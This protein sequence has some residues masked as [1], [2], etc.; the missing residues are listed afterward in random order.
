MRTI[1]LL[2]HHE[3]VTESPGLLIWRV[4]FNTDDPHPYTVSEFIVWIEYDSLYHVA[5]F[6]RIWSVLQMINPTRME[7]KGTTVGINTRAGPEHLPH[8]VLETLADMTLKSRDD[9]EFTW[10]RA[11]NG[12]GYLGRG[13]AT[14]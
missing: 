8:K 2:A 1:P 6:L 9:V 7:H 10:K 4:E 14:S 3:L 11:D 5:D 12:I 13:E